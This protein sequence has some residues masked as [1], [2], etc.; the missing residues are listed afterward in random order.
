P[1]SQIFRLERLIASA[2]QFGYQRLMCAGTLRLGRARVFGLLV[3]LL[4]LAG[5][6][7]EAVA[8]RLELDLSGAWQ[9]QNVT[10]LSFPPSNNWQTITVPGF[11]S[12]WQYD[13]A[14]FRCLFSPPA[15]M[16]GTQLKL[17]FGGVKFN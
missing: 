10:E 7:C 2:F 11:L 8:E 5:P 1:L 4:S 12:G 9:Y 14:W 3:F 6:L 16:A 13:H 17:Q 15:S